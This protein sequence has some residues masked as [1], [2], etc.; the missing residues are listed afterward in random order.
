[1][2][3]YLSIFIVLIFILALFYCIVGCKNKE[4]SSPDATQSTQTAGNTGY[5]LKVIKETPATI[6]GKL[7][8]A[9]M[10]YWIEEKKD[11]I[12]EISYDMNDPEVESRLLELIDKKVS[13]SGTM[14][15]YSNNSEYLVISKSSFDS[16]S[17]K[18]EAGFT[19]DQEYDAHKVSFNG[20]I[21]YKND[22]NSLQIKKVFSIGSDKVALI[23]INSGGTACPAQY[24]FATAKGDGTLSSSAEFG[25]CSDIPNIIAKGDKITVKL[26]G[27][28][29]GTWIYQNGNVKKGI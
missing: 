19:T 25:T 9:S 10:K 7:G 6:S 1:M 4:A 29:P 21:I 23:E 20:K 8:Y 2:R 11:K 28:P 14:K 22:D 12:V 17:G 15:K 3:R 26:P 16:S 24:M 27:N 5:N 13:L 18:K